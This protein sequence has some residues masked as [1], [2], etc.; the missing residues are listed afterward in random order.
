MWTNR[1]PPSHCAFTLCLHAVP[2]HCAFTLRS[3]CSLSLCFHHC[4]LSLWFTMTVLIVVLTSTVLTVT[5]L[6]PLCS[7]C[8]TTVLPMTCSSYHCSDY[9]VQMLSFPHRPFM[10]MGFLDSLGTFFTAMVPY[11]PLHS[12]CTAMVPCTLPALQWC[13]ALCLHSTA[14]CLPS[15]CSARIAIFSALQLHLLTSISSCSA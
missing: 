9:A 3:L 15:N 7:P 13:P 5:V 14:L 1:F 2:S 4:S 10:I 8:S 11:S 6:P 12:A